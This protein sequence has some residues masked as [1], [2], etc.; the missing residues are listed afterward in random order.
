SSHHGDKPENV[1][2][3]AKVNRYHVQNLAYFCDKLSKIPDGDGTVLDHVLIYKGSNM[4]NSHRHAHEKVPVILVGGIDG[5]FKGNRHLVFPDN[6]QRTSN[7]LLSVLHLYGIEMDK[8]G[9][10]TGVL[11]PLEMVERDAP[12]CPGCPLSQCRCVDVWRRASCRRADRSHHASTSDPTAGAAAEGDLSVL[13][14]VSRYRR[15]RV[16]RPRSCGMGCALVEEAPGTG[17]ASAWCRARDPAGLA[18]GQVRPDEQ[19]VS[20]SV[21]R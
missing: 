14:D 2:N 3:Y 18:G 1:A 5:T 12:V 10:S 16:Q 21:R 4:G 8:I 9:T 15:L 6:T 17:R 11:Q 19:A 13:H 7:M 20:S